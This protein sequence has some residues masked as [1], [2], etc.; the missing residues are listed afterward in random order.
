M[1][2]LLPHLNRLFETVSNV[3]T[4]PPPAGAEALGHN[5]KGDQVKW[6]DLAADR[7]VAAYLAEHFPEPVELLSEEG[8]PRRFGR[9]E[10][11]FTLVLD[12][13]DGSE[14]FARGL[15]PSGM[16]VA[17]IPY[18]QPVA[19][20][21]V[22][23]ALVGNLAT[24]QVWAAGRGQGAFLN[25]QPVQTSRVTTIEQA[26]INVDLNNAPLSAQMAGLPA[27]VRGIRSG[28]AATLD[29]ARVANGTFDAHL[30]VRDLLTPENFLAPALIISEAGGVVTGRF[31]EPLPPIQALTDRFSIIAAGTPALHE[32]LVSWLQ[33][34]L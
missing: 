8:E 7:A 9:G 16:A 13:V 6:F 27:Q 2:A 1:Q 32:A 17:V 19:V 12:P 4:G 23:T 14:N 29:L 30:D 11:Q 25:G 34:E 24:G 26:F 5:A 3:V 22:Q 33:R 20:E 18:G 28:G 31:G 21:T 10:P 15:P